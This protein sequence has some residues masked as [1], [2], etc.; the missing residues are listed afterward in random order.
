MSMI[1]RYKKKGGFVQLLNLIETTGGEKKEKFLKMIK[2][3]N[4]G[5]ESEI[6][7]K[8]LTMDKVL[9]WNTSYLMEV[10]PNVPT[11]A[12]AVAISSLPADK[13]QI[14]L[15]ALPFG[16]RKKAEDIMK[17]S[18]PNAG[19][20]FTCQMKILMEVRNQVNSGKLK[21]EKFDPDMVISENIEEQ[22]ASGQTG[23]DIA[24]MMAELPPANAAPGAPAAHGANNEEL[25]ALRKKLVVL[26]Q[27][28]QRLQKENTE[29]KANVSTALT[30]LKKIA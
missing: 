26:T 30:A 28:M 22:L 6:R 11:P 3:E 16:E 25:A 12:L 9:S 4:P 5:W 23:I 29:L 20:V 13:Q 17:D 18:K 15:S 10:I 27:E 2:D 8:M 1:E 24:A 19:E 14:I 21:F 7:K